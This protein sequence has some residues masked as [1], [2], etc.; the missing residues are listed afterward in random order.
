MNDNVMEHNF[1]SQESFAVPFKVK[2]LN[3]ESGLFDLSRPQKHMPILEESIS[4]GGKD[5]KTSSP[6]VSPRGGATTLSYV[7]CLYFYLCFTLT[8]ILSNLKR[9]IVN[10]RQQELAEQDDGRKK[11]ET[12]R[13]ILSK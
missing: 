9:M 13:P 1:D 3:F 5:S 6:V 12:S 11:K 4:R 2:P 10:M 7:H 8:M